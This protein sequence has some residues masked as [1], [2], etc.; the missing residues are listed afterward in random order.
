MPVQSLREGFS[1]KR[2]TTAATFW[3]VSCVG[4]AV[5]SGFFVGA[6]VATFV[7]YL[8]LT[9]SQKVVAKG[10]AG[11]ALY[12]EVNELCHECRP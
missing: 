12:I 2:L 10:H 6:F 8:T 3:A 5:G 11:K 4:L 7:I 1:V 9:L